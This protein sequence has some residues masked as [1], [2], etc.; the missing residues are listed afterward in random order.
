VKILA[1]LEPARFAQRPDI[2]SMSEV[3]PAFRKPTSWFGFF[4]PPSL[5]APMVTRLN[6]EI[7]KALNAPD[8]RAK[9]AD[10][11]M[12]VLGGTP[13]DFAALIEDGIARYGAIIKAAGVQPE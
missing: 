13:Q 4:G 6:T 9:L 11:G 2:P 8:V 7:V 1:V 3:L 5:P 10:N 12:A